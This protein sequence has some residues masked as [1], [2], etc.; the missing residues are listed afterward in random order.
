[1]KCELENQWVGGGYWYCH[2]CDVD[3]TRE[4]NMWIAKLI[5]SR[6]SLFNL[7]VFRKLKDAIRWHTS[8]KAKEGIK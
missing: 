2:T 4:D 6:G 8:K 3:F 1:M 5:T 7:K